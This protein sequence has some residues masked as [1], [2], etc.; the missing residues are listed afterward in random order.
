MPSTEL[1]AL[2]EKIHDPEKRALAVKISDDILRI[3]TSYAITLA[4]CEQLEQH[5]NAADLHALRVIFKNG[6]VDWGTPEADRIQAIILEFIDSPTFVQYPDFLTDS[7][8]TDT[9]SLEYM[10]N[11]SQKLADL[12]GGG[13]S[14]GL[15]ILGARIVNGVVE[16][17]MLHNTVKSVSGDDGCM[18]FERD[19][20]KIPP[21][22]TIG[23][24]KRNPPIHMYGTGG[25][26]YVSMRSP[27]GYNRNS[28]NDSIEVVISSAR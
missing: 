5:P 13:F 19:R 23:S 15:E 26:M 27:Y 3:I 21:E 18:V 17:L 22:V 6:L 9:A 25:E 11:H 28:G 12:E 8:I 16:V 10:E 1:S 7:T 14:P 2:L 24:L 4:D 20:L